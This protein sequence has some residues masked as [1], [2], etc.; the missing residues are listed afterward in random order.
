MVYTR[1]DIYIV[2]VGADRVNNRHSITTFFFFGLRHY[3]SDTRSCTA[4]CRGSVGISVC[5]DS[6]DDLPPCCAPRKRVFTSHIASDI[7]TL[8]F[9]VAEEPGADGLVLCR[10]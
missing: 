2:Y 6:V 7:D 10:L 9:R 5:S 8:D 3:H 1:V 4:L